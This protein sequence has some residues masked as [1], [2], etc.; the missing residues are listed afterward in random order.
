VATV[1][2]WVKTKKSDVGVKNGLR[3]MYYGAQKQLNK[4]V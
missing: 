1:R 3:L 4:S 2:K